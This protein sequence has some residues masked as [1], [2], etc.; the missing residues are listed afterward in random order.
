MVKAKSRGGE[1]RK[2]FQQDVTVLKQFGFVKQ[3]KT[4]YLRGVGLQINW[5]FI[6]ES[7]NID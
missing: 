1:E 3:K 5:P 6:I 7:M 4:P 2:P